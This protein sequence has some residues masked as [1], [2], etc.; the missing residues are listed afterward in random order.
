MR[1]GAAQLPAVQMD[2][3]SDL[4]RAAGTCRRNKSPRKRWYDGKALCTDLRNVAAPSGGAS[5]VAPVRAGNKFAETKAERTP[6]SRDHQTMQIY[7]CSH[8]IPTSIKGKDVLQ[9][10]RGDEDREKR[11]RDA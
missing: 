3:D 7:A 6:T 8:L 5:C 2:L 10:L 11:L 4:T 1:P 9:R